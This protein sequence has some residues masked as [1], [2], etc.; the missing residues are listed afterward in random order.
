MVFNGH[1][2]QN[3][4]ALDEATLNNIVVMYADGLIGNKGILNVMG[5][6]TSGVFN[7]MR[8][9][10]SQ[11]YALKSI[12]GSA[13]GYMYPDSELPTNDSLLTFMSQAPGFEL[14]KFKRE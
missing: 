7:Y 13:Y 12:L 9:P 14:G 8:S 5:T 2:T 10:N 1:T 11:P 4:D 6:L 3:I